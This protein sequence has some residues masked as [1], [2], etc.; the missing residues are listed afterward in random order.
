M[1]LFQS[2]DICASGM[3]AQRFRMDTIADNIA[4]INTT[5]TEDG[6][7]Y[8]RKVVTFTE[9][10]LGSSSFAD[11]LDKKQAYLGNGVKVSRVYEDTDTDPNELII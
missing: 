8:T 11:I 7:P 2:F 4:N 5:R 9:K 6:G 3:T 1:G 10:T